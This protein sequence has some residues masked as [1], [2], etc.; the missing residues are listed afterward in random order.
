MLVNK[1]KLIYLTIYKLL[2][3][4]KKVNYNRYEFFA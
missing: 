1:Q 4:I 2:V 3:P